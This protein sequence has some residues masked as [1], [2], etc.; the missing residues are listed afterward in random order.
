MDCF[1]SLTG[2]FMN[3][4]LQHLY[5][6]IWIFLCFLLIA[7]LIYRLKAYFYKKRNKKRI[8]NY[9]ANRFVALV[10]ACNEEKGI[11]IA[12][13]SLYAQKEIERTYVVLNN[14]TDSTPEILNRLV[15]EY[16]DW[17]IVLNM[18]YNPHFKS[19]AL[20]YGL[21][22][23]NS[24]IG[25]F[26]NDY[27]VLTLDAD[28]IVGDGICEEVL[29]VFKSNPAAGGLNIPCK[30]QSLELIN[31][32]Q[33]P[34]LMQSI[35]Y[36]FQDIE[37]TLS[38]PTKYSQQPN[39]RILAGACAAFRLCA[40]QEVCEK[41]DVAWNPATIVEDYNLSREL[42]AIG[43]ETPSSN[44]IAYTDAPIDSKTLYKQ[45][46][47]WYKGA[48]LLLWGDLKQKFSLADA[49]Q[50]FRIL[51]LPLG[52]IVQVLLLTYL[53]MYPDW[54]RV[55]SIPFFAMSLINTTLYALNSKP[56][57]RP[58]LS[59]VFAAIPIL[60]LFYAIWDEVIYLMSIISSLTESEKKG[61]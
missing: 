43:W 47:R 34:S 8:N 6:Y 58:F 16:G 17:L 45:R 24:R 50:L 44:A 2:V 48:I 57:N 14:T 29:E 55:F 27:I 37:Y 7:D 13:R 51:I 56:D 32:N 38:L 11:E 21:K 54:F 1:F 42:K 41:Y 9:M 3:T 12:I 35:W 15:Q 31:D 33:V 60:Y 30:L 26:S 28:T 49:F 61:W 22:E 25:K 36:S 39:V 19:G 10:A 23:I 53:F 20:N 52:L 59:W 5:F 46:K 18:D 4:M 40:L